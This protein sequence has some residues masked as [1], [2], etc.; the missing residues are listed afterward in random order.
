M[1]DSTARVAVVGAGHGGTAAVALLRQHGFAGTV[2]L[3]GA[4]RHLPYH[5]P[6]LS[7][8]ARGS[9]S[10]H[11]EPLRPAEFYRDQDIELRLD[12]AVAALDPVAARLRL[13]DGSTLAYDVA[14][15]ATGARPK[16]LPVPG[17]EL[18]GVHT[19]RTL[20]D[21][22]SIAEGLGH[23]RRLVV[24]G[25]GYIGLEVAA[26]AGRVGVAVTVLEAAERVLG[27]SAGPDLAAWLTERHRRRGTEVVVSAAV[28]R[29]VP[30]P[31]GRVAAVGLVGGGEVRCDL[32]LVGI[33][34]QPRDEL[35]RAA[36]LHCDDGVVGDERARTSAPG[37]YAIGDVT[38]RPLPHCDG[39]H[40]LESIPSAGEQAKQAVGDML[41]LPPPRPE[42]PWFWSDQFDLKVKIAGL[43]SRAEK[44]VLR[45]DPADERT[46]CAFHLDGAARVVAVETVNAGGEFMAA[47]RWIADRAVVDPDGLADSGR[48]LRSLALGGAT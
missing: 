19:L 2:T 16:R 44:S 31:D 35:A 15:L 6:P 10:E 38:R 29:F 11:G 45:G 37:V 13:H 25:G 46:F 33:G 14:V 47:K 43:P 20:E 3:L 42:V 24:V 30:G 22:T 1:I 26:M 32:A 40:R 36:G 4:E 41:G 28:E 21:A 39:L 23:G 12:A 8:T 9:G 17:S 48:S 5:R 18:P 7:K 27:R 34:A